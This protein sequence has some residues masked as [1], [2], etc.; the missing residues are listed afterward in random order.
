MRGCAASATR[1]APGTVTPQR[2]RGGGPNDAG[3]PR[4]RS[5]DPNDI[6]D[7]PT[8]L[9]DGPLPQPS[10]DAAER[11]R[12][13]LQPSPVPRRGEVPAAAI[14]AAEACVRQLQMELT[15]LGASGN[16]QAAAVEAV[17]LRAG[18]RDPVVEPG[19][20]FAASTGSACI[21]GS[22]TGT[23]PSLAIAPLTQAGACKP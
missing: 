20:A 1:E 14:P 22:F 6:L 18:L 4:P 10:D 16:L 17:L 7:F 15:L 23:E 11:R 9:P 19:P 5:P 8:D 3:P 21:V 2:S 13:A 12:K